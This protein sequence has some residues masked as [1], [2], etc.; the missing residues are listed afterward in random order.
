MTHR[1]APHRA[2]MVRFARR[3]LIAAGLFIAAAAPAAEAA[4]FGSFAVRCDQ[5][6]SL[7]DD[8]IVA[9]G[10]PG[11][12]HLHEFA[13]NATASAHSTLASLR[14][15]AATTRCTR[16]VDGDRRGSGDLSAYWAPALVQ[17]GPDGNATRI[18]GGEQVV[19]Y[20]QNHASSR[21]VRSFPPGL[22]MIAGNS[23]ATR[24]QP[25]DVVRW[26]CDHGR[27]LDPHRPECED[28]RPN[29]G[30]RPVL[31]LEVNFPSCWDGIQ[32][33]ATGDD[34]RHMAYAIS[35]RGRRTCPSSHPLP[36]P[37]LQQFI[38]YQS[39]GGPGIELASGGPYSGHA[40]FFNAWDGEILDKLV[41]NCIHRRVVC[42]AGD[43]ARRSG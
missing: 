1:A 28:V 8:P 5:D 31:R 19:Y 4:R 38:Y 34:T 6:H 29:D 9:F 22:K 25:L 14:A 15:P 36:V 35:R 3:A 2:A 37:R 27:I 13:G 20:W 30:R 33:S 41:V 23:H 18:P 11:G 32:P 10:R 40:D 39:P 42:G 26:H 16:D 43:R 24:P 21:A 12:A 17:R 7:A